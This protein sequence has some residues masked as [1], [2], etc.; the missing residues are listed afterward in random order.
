MILLRTSWLYSKLRCFNKNIYAKSLML[1]E[2][3][4]FE[5]RILRLAWL[6]LM[7]AAGYVLRQGWMVFSAAPVSSTLADNA[8]IQKRS[9]N[10]M[11]SPNV[12]P[13]SSADET[14]TLTLPSLFHLTPN[15]SPSAISVN[16]NDP[17]QSLSSVNSQTSPSARWLMQVQ[18]VPILSPSTLTLFEDAR[19]FLQQGQ[20]EQAQFIYAQALQQDPHQL[21]AL[22]GM[23]YISQM[24]ADNEQYEHFLQRVQQLIPGVEANARLFA[25]LLEGE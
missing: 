12:Q 18:R 24:R 15:A 5:Q 7:I 10:Q 19:L 11:Q 1:S 17:A 23:L 25:Q 3:Q 14:S 6:I 9:F 22:V 4:Q 16:S 21:Q 13:P 2:W 8:I 20:F